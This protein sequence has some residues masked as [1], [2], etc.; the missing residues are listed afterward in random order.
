M[1]GE[2]ACWIPAIC[3]VMYSTVTGSST[4]SLWLWHSTRALSIK[5]RPSA[6]RP[7]YAN[8]HRTSLAIINNVPLTIACRNA[9]TCEG[10]T[11]VIVKH[12]HLPDRAWILELQDRFLLD[13]EHH[14]V[15][16]SNADLVPVQFNSI[17]SHRDGCRRARC[18]YST[19]PLL[20]GFQS[21]FDL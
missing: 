6:V 15:C 9:R 4:V 2:L 13:A 12:D 1:N 14:H 18:T 16:A 10:E 20:D 7:S 17:T 21:I 19:C 8:E 3:L 5:T 11:Y